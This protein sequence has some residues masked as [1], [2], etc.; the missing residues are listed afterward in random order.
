MTAEYEP[1]TPTQTKAVVVTA[2]FAS[3]RASTMRSRYQ[4]MDPAKTSTTAS[5]R[6]SSPFQ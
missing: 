6:A 2:T 5:G 1:S 3:G 4:V